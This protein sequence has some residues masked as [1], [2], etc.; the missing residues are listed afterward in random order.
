MFRTP[1]SEDVLSA[2]RESAL[3]MP[4]EASLSLFPGER[5]P[6]ERWR[7]TVRAMTRAVLYVVTPPLAEQA[8]SLK[9][10]R[11]ATQIEIFEAAGHALFVDEAERFS[12]LLADFLRRNGFA[13]APP[14]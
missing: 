8:Q 5:I 11:P 13:P 2:L 12:A 1:Q 4:L 10:H 6:R 7:D 9:A 3:R 14:D